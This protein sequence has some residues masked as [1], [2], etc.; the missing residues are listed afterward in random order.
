MKII[1]N[2]KII[3]ITNPTDLIYIAIDGV[4]PRS[5]V[6]QQ[7]YRRFR[8]VN[9]NKVWDTN[10]ISPGTNF[11]NNLNIFLLYLPPIHKYC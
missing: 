3:N 7:K 11:M 5:K 1:I 9:E 4:C 6:E 8:S 2:V 10:A